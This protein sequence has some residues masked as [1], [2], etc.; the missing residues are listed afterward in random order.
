VLRSVVYASL[1]EYPLTRAQLR[2]TL[3][4]VEAD[5]ATLAG[6]LATS[7]LLEAAIDERDGFYFPRGQSHLLELRSRRERCSL[8]LLG[9][10]A[11]VLRLL[12]HM[13]FV[14]MIAVSGSLAHLNAD[15]DA[16]LDLF[17]ITRAGRVWSVTTTVL[18]LA[19]VFG[20]RKHLCL[21]YVVSERQLEVQPAD[22][23]SANQIIHLRPLTGADTYSRFLHANAFVRQMYPNFRSKETDAPPTVTCSA[24]ASKWIRRFERSIDVTVG[25]LYE[26]VCRRAYR[27]YLQRQAPGWRSREHVR[28]EDECLKLH[29]ASHRAEVMS[30]FEAAVAEALHAA[31]MVE[32]G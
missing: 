23:F 8:D 21:N 12:A 26:R 13:P 15:R 7:A 25:P 22:L 19:R 17:V 16:D 6:W 32:A 27:W 9:A 30:R 24:A 10:Q 31:R 5:E 11:S 4:G 2:D 20:W 18:I 3:V 1:F 29:T 28:L 14:R